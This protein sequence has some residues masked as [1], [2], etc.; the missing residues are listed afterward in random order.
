LFVIRADFSDKYNPLRPNINAINKNTLAVGK[1]LRRNKPLIV[2]PA[3][4]LRA[5]IFENILLHFISP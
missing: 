3:R 5:L 4:K 2:D 1:I